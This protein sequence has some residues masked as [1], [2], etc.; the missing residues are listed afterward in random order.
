MQRITIALVV[1][2]LC[3]V[4]A[5]ASDLNIR[6]I[7]FLGLKLEMGEAEA[8]QKLT[9]Q[10]FDLYN[11]STEWYRY[12]KMSENG[13]EKIE[14]R[15][16][17]TRDKQIWKLVHKVMPEGRTRSRGPA[18]RYLEL[19]RRYGTPD[20][21]GPDRARSIWR[22][23]DEHGTPT[24]TIESRGETAAVLEWPALKVAADKR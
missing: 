21:G 7:E 18:P 11:S 5:Q 9:G 10:G 4:T 14:V 15:F 19:I 8:K 16:Y 24:L 13:S 22:E 1:L 6:E 23:S 12:H 17:L 3:A 20:E 2:L